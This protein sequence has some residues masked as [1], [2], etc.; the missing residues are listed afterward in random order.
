VVRERYPKASSTSDIR[1]IAISISL[2]ECFRQ[3]K[4]QTKCNAPTPT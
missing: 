1:L 3:S 2:V 4:T